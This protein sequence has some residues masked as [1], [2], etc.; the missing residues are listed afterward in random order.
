MITIETYRGH[1]R[2]WRALGAE[3]GLWQEMRRADGSYPIL[4][5]EKREKDIL[6]K[7]YAVWGKALPDHLHGMFAFAL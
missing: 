6:V 1:I 4:D 2:N 7:G 5:R 3:L